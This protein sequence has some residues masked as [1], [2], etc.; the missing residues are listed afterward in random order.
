MDFVDIGDHTVAIFY[1][2]HSHSV[3]ELITQAGARRCRASSTWTGGADHHRSAPSGLEP[4]VTELVPP[5]HLHLPLH[6]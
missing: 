4:Y 2:D 5:L 6:L 3:S 1:K